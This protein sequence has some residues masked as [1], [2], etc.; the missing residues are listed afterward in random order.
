MARRY[1]EELKQIMVGKYEGGSTAKTI[2]AEYGVSRSTLLLW[3]KQY[4]PDSS[5][6]IPRE[7]YL[8][9]KEL[10]RLRIENQI[11]RECGCSANSS[12]GNRLDAIHRLKDKYSI[13]ALCRVL[14][15]NRSTVYHHE[16]RTPEKTQ[17]ELQDEILKPL[18]EEIFKNSNELFGVRRMRVKLKEKG[19]VVSERRIGRL[20]KE[21]GLYVKKNGPRL[22][23]ANDRQYQYYPNRLQRNFLTEAPN[24][25]WVSDI[26]YARVGHDFLYLCV[27]IDL[28]ARKVVS[29]AV[30]EYIDEG[31]VTEA[32]ERAYKSRAC[33]KGLLFHS[34]QG[35]QY[36]AFEFR[37]KLREYD[38]TQSFSAPGNP[39]DNAVIESFFATI[40]KEDFRKNFYKTEAEFKIAVSKYIDF[41][42]DYRPHQRLGYLTPNQAEDEYYKSHPDELTR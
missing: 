23:S 15:V 27:V 20:M 36:T 41:Y 12:L 6:Q 25:V 28:Y 21:L 17:V 39:Y 13:H 24:M 5:G 3:V 34:D 32:F 7:Q 30:S 4:S 16:L 31:L 8:M 18:I 19:Y 33:P 11:L 29:Y 40:K 42:N 14:N 38:V 37:K 26:T 35:T 10:E 22:N 2:C 1:S 9:R